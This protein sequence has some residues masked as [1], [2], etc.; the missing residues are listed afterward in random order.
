MQ[1]INS[2]IFFS[3]I[4]TICLVLCVEVFFPIGLLEGL[5]ESTPTELFGKNATWIGIIGGVGFVVFELLFIRSLLSSAQS[6][7]PKSRKNSNDTL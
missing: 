4:A 5:F 7:K 1:N 3:T 2:I 6:G